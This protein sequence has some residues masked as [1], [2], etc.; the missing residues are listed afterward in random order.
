MSKWSY[1]RSDVT[2]HV[3]VTLEGDAYQQ[4]QAVVDYATTNSHTILGGNDGPGSSL[5]KLSTDTAGDFTE[6]TEDG[7]I[8][9]THEIEARNFT[10]DNL[11]VGFVSR[12]ISND[13]VEIHHGRAISDDGSII[14][15]ITE[16]V[17]FDITLG[18]AAG[19]LDAGVRT[20]NTWY[21]IWLV[22]NPDTGDIHVRGSVSKTSPTMPTGYVYKVLVGVVRNDGSDKFVPFRAFG[23][24]HAKQYVYLDKMNI[25][26]GGN[27]TTKTAVDCSSLVPEFEEGYPFCSCL[28]TYD[29]DDVDVY[30][31]DNTNVSAQLKSSNASQNNTTLLDTVVLNDSGEFSYKGNAAAA[32]VSVDILSFDLEL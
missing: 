23:H 30:Y 2:P 18:V 7:T 10:D 28:F 14:I 27:A 19:G 17:V 21:Y 25:L 9:F 26:T 15:K 3:T 13:K 32:N 20:P 22:C 24:D 12:T 4:R 5:R 1:I 8:K 6:I 16:D 29:A 11:F 31:A